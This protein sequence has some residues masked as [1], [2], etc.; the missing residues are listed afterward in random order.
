MSMPQLSFNWIGAKVSWYVNCLKSYII[1][2]NLEIADRNEIPFICI[3]LFRSFHYVVPCRIQPLSLIES[4][5]KKP[6]LK[7]PC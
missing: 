2:L 5:P 3:Y 6:S 4:F 7:H 1:V